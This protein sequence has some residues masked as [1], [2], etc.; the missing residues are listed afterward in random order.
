MS[1]KLTRDQYDELERVYNDAAE[2]E[3]GGIGGR[4]AIL[5]AVLYRL[6]HGVM[7]TFQAMRQ[8]EKLLAQLWKEDTDD[9]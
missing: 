4:H 1:D 5:V 7:S 6:G 3:S 8:A 2:A 9:G